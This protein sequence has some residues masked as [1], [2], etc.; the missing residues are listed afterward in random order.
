[1]RESQEQNEERIW[2]VGWDGHRLAQLRRFAARP[3]VEKLRWLEE[4][5][6]LS[7]QIKRPDSSDERR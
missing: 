5:Q 4:A 6:R 3:F 7:N 2:E 1:M